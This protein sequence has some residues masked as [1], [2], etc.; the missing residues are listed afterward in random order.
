MLVD[1]DEHE[2]VFAR[3]P[4]LADQTDP[5]L[6]ELD[7]LL[8]D[9]DDLYQD[10]LYQQVRRDRVRRYRLP[11]VPGRHSTP[12]E[13]L[14]RLLVV[15]HLYTW[16]FAAPVERVADSLVLRW[17]CR[18]YFRRAPDATILLRSRADHPPDDA[19]GPHRPGGAIRC[20]I[21]CTEKPR[22]RKK[23]PWSLCLIAP[24]A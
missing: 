21:W 17:C 9:E 24:S 14:L 16:S 22:P 5:V 13:V 7:R 11:P 4:E 18:V 10:D 15:K 8:D 1:R 2:D 23:S 19:A 12:G 20:N 6:V 3:V